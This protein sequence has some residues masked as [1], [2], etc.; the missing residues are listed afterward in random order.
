ML[1]TGDTEMENTALCVQSSHTLVGKS[2]EQADMPRGQERLARLGR[3]ATEGGPYQGG[4]SEIQVS[5]RGMGAKFIRMSRNS[6]SGGKEKGQKGISGTRSSAAIDLGARECCEVWNHPQPKK[7]RPK[8]G[9]E[10]EGLNAEIRGLDI[11]LR[12]EEGSVDT[13][14][15]FSSVTQSCST[16]SDPMDCSTP[17]FPVHP[18]FLEPTQTHVH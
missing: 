18:Q 7:P 12:F 5:R 15:Q 4:P 14:H 16:L 11:A 1:G 9:G 17:G 13:G 8:P 3:E 10:V 6:P 2:D